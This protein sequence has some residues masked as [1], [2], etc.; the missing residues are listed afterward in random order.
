MQEILA[1]QAFRRSV[2]CAHSLFS[3]LPY[4]I[5][6]MNTASL[7]ASWKPTDRFGW[8]LEREQF[9][10]ESLSHCLLTPFLLIYLSTYLL[11]YLSTY[12]LKFLVF[13]FFH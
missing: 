9:R 1:L 2:P 13:A 4:E 6:P 12:L 3:C 8:M 10:S 7:N 11:I 5:N